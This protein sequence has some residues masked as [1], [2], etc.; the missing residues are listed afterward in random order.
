MY[1]DLR[2]HEYFHISNHFYR[3]KI[4][5]NHS[6][7]LTNLPPL[8]YTNFFE[9]KNK[10]VMVMWWFYWGMKPSMNW[11][12]AEFYKNFVQNSYYETASG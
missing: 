7:S 4:V 2:H 1:D 5:I 8:H 6:N 12:D 9:G 10:K 11:A 3:G